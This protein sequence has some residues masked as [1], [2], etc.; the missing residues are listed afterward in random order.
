MGGK[1]TWEDKSCGNAHPVGILKILS[2]TY[3]SQSVNTLCIVEV[4]LH[5]DCQ[6]EL[7]LLHIY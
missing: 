5:F 7:G 4:V 2:Y 1:C 6:K 3:H